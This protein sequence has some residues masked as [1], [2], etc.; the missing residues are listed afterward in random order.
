MFSIQL[1]RCLQR[2]EICFEAT[3]STVSSSPPCADLHLAASIS[4]LLLRWQI[5]QEPYTYITQI[6]GK[7]IRSQLIQAFNLWLKVPEEKLE[8]IKSVTKILHNASLLS[9]L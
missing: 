7:D 3:P 9:V 2:P 5:L 6:P 1:L 4:S 8:A